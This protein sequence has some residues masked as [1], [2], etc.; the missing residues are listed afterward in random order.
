MK[1]SFV[2]KV[3][4][5]CLSILLCGF[6][7]FPL[8]SSDRKSLEFTVNDCFLIKLNCLKYKYKSTF[9]FTFTFKSSNID[10]INECWFYLRFQRLK[11]KGVAK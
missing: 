4:S 7:C 3:K 9:T 5:K 8:N 1:K 6:E 2:N 10:L 11:N